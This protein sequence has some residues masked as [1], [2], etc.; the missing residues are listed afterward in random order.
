[1]ATANASQQPPGGDHLDAA[2]GALRLLSDP[3]RLKL[4]WLLSQDEYDVSTLVELVDAPRASVSQHLA[5]LRLAGMAVVR[6]DGRRMIYR[7]K[8]N[9]IRT[10]I[11]EVLN[12]A[13]HLLHD[14]PGEGTD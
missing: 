3:T 12:H 2:V 1:M 11:T 8:N 5:K 9:H 6:R 7:A 10:L 13:D 4:L 14:K